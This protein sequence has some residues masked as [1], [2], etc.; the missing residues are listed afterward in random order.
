MVENHLL[1]VGQMMKRGTTIRGPPPAKWR[2]LCSALVIQWPFFPA[3]AVSSTIVSEKPLEAKGKGKW[4]LVQHLSS[5]KWKSVGNAADHQPNPIPATSKR[6]TFWQ[7]WSNPL[8]Q[9]QC[10]IYLKAVPQLGHHCNTHKFN[11]TVAQTSKV[12]FGWFT[13]TQ[14]GNADH[15]DDKCRAIERNL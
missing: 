5:P 6:G 3:I 9:K 1:S 14:P 15:V 2:F 10:T 11:N 8:P 7:A 13:T 4:H 12:S